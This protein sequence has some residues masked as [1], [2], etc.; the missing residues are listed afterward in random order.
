MRC[1][2]CSELQQIA[3]NLFECYGREQTGAILRQVVVHLLG[4]GNA[5]IAD[6]KVGQANR[7]E[8]V[9]TR[10]SRADSPT[11]R[12]QYVDAYA[13]AVHRRM[14]VA[15][16]VPVEPAPQLVFNFAAEQPAL[17]PIPITPLTT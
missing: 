6:G 10:P 15:Q 12:A 4:F 3:A 13:R 17:T 5:A 7:G 1:L 14:V 2:S 8:Q 16:L 11:E 9:T